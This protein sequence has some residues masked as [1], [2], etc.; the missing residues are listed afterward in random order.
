MS[1]NSTDDGNLISK[2][3]GFLKLHP[4]SS[5]RQIKVGIGA[6][7]KT[8]INS[9]LYAQ[10][11]VR[12]QRVGE[13]PPLWWNSSDP[14]IGQESLDLEVPSNEE[15]FSTA[16]AQIPLYDNLEES[17]D[18]DKFGAAEPSVGASSNPS[19]RYSICAKCGQVVGSKSRCGCQ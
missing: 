8:E 17:D 16:E 11:G 18:V 4:G 9:C 10:I 19:V 14:T 15:Y 12:F 5:A 2:I 1:P 7:N 3:E 6:I 13:A